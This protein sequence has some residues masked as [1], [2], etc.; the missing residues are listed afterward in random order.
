[1]EVSGTL[2][3]QG[4]LVTE[5]AEPAAVPA[6]SPPLPLSKVRPDLFQRSD[7]IGL[8]H[9]AGHFVILTATGAAITKVVSLLSP[10][11]IALHGLVLSHLYMPF[12]EC[13]HGTAF[14][15]A[16]INK[17]VGYILGFLIFMNADSFRWF[18]REHHDQTQ[19]IGRDPELPGA[20]GSI[21]NYLHKLLG[22]EMLVALYYFMQSVIHGEEAE[23][24]WT[25]EDEKQKV[26]ASSRIQVSMYLL[27]FALALVSVEARWWITH[28]WILPLI[29]GQPF[30]WGHFIAQH[31]STDHDR[32]A[33]HTARV[34][35]TNP[36]YAWLCWNM[37]YHA[38]HH[39]YPKIPNHKLAEAFGSNE[40]KDA[41][42][43]VERD[44][45]YLGAHQ[46]VLKNICNLVTL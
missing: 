31:T 11:A 39:M 28:L 17:S 27:I 12:H 15:S 36:F 23:P 29:M 7:A 30:M 21:R 16:R 45:G 19:V 18:H 13:N 22:G 5:P 33:G 24:P 43:Y 1:M 9:L 25:P 3:T 42:K 4:S 6:M 46:S 26:V 44:H 20:N 8:R 41:F 40:L 37:N 14:A 34:V 38:V 35:L 10:L 2:E 32:D